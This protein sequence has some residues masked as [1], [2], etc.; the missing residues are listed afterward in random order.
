MIFLT[1]KYTPSLLKKVINE[2][3]GFNQYYP[4]EKL[5]ICTLSN[6]ISA[7]GVRLIPATKSLIEFHLIKNSNEDSIK[8]MFV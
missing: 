1:C 3:L 8:K 2:Y 6:N 5:G 7:C 4:E